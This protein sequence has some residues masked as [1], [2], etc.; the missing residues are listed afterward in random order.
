[1]LCKRAVTIVNLDWRLFG[2]FESLKQEVLPTNA[3]DFY[4]KVACGGD[5]HFNVG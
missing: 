1:M 4:P 3:V 2:V 5:R